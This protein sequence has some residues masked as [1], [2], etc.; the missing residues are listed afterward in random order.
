MGGNDLSFYTEILCIENHP[1][2]AMSAVE[3][4]PRPCG[5]ANIVV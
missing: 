2:S 4:I 1:A 5:V 3:M